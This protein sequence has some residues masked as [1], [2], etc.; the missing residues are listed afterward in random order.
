MNASIPH[1]MLRWDEPTIKFVGCHFYL[2][3]SNIK[4][5]VKMD[6]LLLENSTV[7][8]PTSWF[9]KKQTEAKASILNFA[10]N[11]QH[12]NVDVTSYISVFSC[13]LATLVQWNFL[14][15]AMWTVDNS[16]RT[17]R[18]SFLLIN[19]RVIHS[20]SCQNLCRGK[21]AKETPKCGITPYIFFL[22]C[23][24]TYQM[25]FQG[26]SS[27]IG[28]VNKYCVICSLQLYSKYAWDGYALRLEI[29]SQL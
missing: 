5:Y 16:L 2:F 17:Q 12:L 23:F 24:I 25:S 22:C 10:P 19:N 4:I 18:Y 29:H 11:L 3:E 15:L 28:I 7:N 26:Y 6:K 9:L 1:A 14:K 27:V 21:L 13:I 20:R 8:F